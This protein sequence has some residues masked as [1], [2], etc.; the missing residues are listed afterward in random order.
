MKEIKEIE[1]FQCSSI[2][3][4]NI[5]KFQFFPPWFIDSMQSPQKSSK[6]FMDIDKLML[7]LM[8]ERKKTQYSQLKIQ[9][10]QSWESD[11]IWLQDLL[12]SY[13]HQDSVVLV[14]EDINRSV[15]K[16]TEPRNKPREYNQ[17]KFD[18]RANT[19]EWRKDKCFYKWC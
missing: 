1:W 17:L 8:V 19:T 16:D 11:T 7:K 13:S 2:V 18:K 4:N 6:L 3:R 9:G 15:K 14:N 12:Y 10:E 5:L